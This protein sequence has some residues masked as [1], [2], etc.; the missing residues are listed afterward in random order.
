MYTVIHSPLYILLH[1]E[2]ASHLPP[3]PLRNEGR[4]DGGEG[5]R[6]NPRK[7]EDIVWSAIV[8]SKNQ[9]ELVKLLDQYG[10]DITWVDE[11]GFSGRY[12]NPL[13]LAKDWGLDDVV[14]Y[15]E[16]RGCT[17]PPADDEELSTAPVI[18]VEQAVIDHFT[19]SVGT[20]E[21]MVQIEIVPTGLRFRSIA[22]RPANN[23]PLSPCSQ[24]ACRAYR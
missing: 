17:M 3:S 18:S 23:I 6:A 13:S 21:K 11:G 1:T 8:R 9:L 12:A 20:P 10:A 19:A 5:Q 7:K 22:Y 4:G 14:A 2:N 16:S 24:R 15:L